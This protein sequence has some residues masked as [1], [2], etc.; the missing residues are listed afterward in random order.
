MEFDSLKTQVKY[1]SLFLEFL[2]WNQAPLANSW[3]ELTH[4]LFSLLLPSATF[5]PCWAANKGPL[6]H[7][8]NSSLNLNSYPIVCFWNDLNYYDN[9]S[10]V[11]NI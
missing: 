8:P 11:E 2:C 7:L 1:L 3:S 9:Q 6:G 4:V 5:F 10:N